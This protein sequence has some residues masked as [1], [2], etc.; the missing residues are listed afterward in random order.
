MLENWFAFILNSLVCEEKNFSCSNMSEPW[1]RDT[2]AFSSLIITSP[3]STQ[4]VTRYS[5]RPAVSVS[6]VSVFALLLHPNNPSS[7]KECLQF[8]STELIL[9]ACCVMSHLQYSLNVLWILIQTKAHKSLN[10]LHY[11]WLL[12]FVTDTCNISQSGALN[13]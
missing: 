7:E 8:N 12:L 9:I 3:F 10:S 13:L 5:T 11:S 4:S 2:I 1:H 6:A